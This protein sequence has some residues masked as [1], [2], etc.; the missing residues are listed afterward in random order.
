[1]Q[2]RS[3]SFLAGLQ[4]GLIWHHGGALV[5]LGSRGGA[6]V[7]EQKRTS[8]WCGEGSICLGQVPVGPTGAWAWIVMKQE[9]VKGKE[10]S[11]EAWAGWAQAGHAGQE[12][13]RAGD[14]QVSPLE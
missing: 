13:V 14:K 2:G 4:P 12:Q 8:R 3:R 10:S 6:R 1:M 7:V 11:A 5:K 9:G